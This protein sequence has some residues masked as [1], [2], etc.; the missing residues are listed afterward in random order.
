MKKFIK[1]TFIFLLL[2]IAA[3]CMLPAQ[4]EHGNDLTIKIAVMG[5]GDELY[6]W[7][8]HIGL[9]IENTRTGQSRFYD[10]GLFSF[11]KENFF[12]NFAFGRLWYS[13]GVSLASSNIAGYIETNRDVVLY[14]LDLPPEKR[15]KVWRQA[16]WDIQPE[17]RDYLYNHFSHN[18]ATP[19]I[20]IIDM[21]TDGQ[22]KEQYKKEQGRFTLR[23]HVRRHTWFSP[24]VDWILNFWMG[25]GIDTSITVWDEMF[26][27]SEVGRC[28]SD[29]QYTD[30]H[31][32]SRPLVSATEVIYKA[33]DR[34]AVLDFPHR[35]WPVELAFS[36]FLS[37]ILGY[38][39][40]IQS[41]STARGQVALGMT[42]SLFGLIFGVAGSLLLFMSNFTDHDYTWHN[43]NI[44]FCNPLLLAAVPLGIRY[45]VSRNYDSRLRAEFMLRIL[46]LLVVLGIFASMLIKLLPQFWQQNLTDQMLMLPIALVLSLEPAGLKRLIERIFWR[47]L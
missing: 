44:L 18:C 36:L 12:V 23:Q 32:V 33:Y 42:H 41:K 45:A 21:A 20:N 6:F 19:I 27:P 46:W 24:L 43:T 38:F 5:P 28:I 31:G 17:N 22:F 34:P 13:C 9:V 4:A 2:G 26:L 10:Y 3:I 35:Q 15:E 40:Y 16:E 37:L 1:R 11:D 14:T 47:W 8:G 30:S 25:Q 7:W 29:F 39:F